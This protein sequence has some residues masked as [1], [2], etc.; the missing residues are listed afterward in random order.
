MLTQ[1]DYM[2]LTKRLGQVGASQLPMHYLLAMRAPYSPTQWLTRLSHEQLKASHQMLGRIIYLLL[3]LHAAFYLNFFV[4][5]GFL[6]KRIKDWDVIFGIISITLFTIVSTTA[7]SFVRRRSYRVFY[8]SHIAIANLIIVPLYLH[9]SHIRIIVYQ[10]VLVEALHVI[11]R[12]LRFRLYQGTIRL[13]P[14][15]NLV[16]IRVPLP[17]SSSALK[18]RPGQHV[19]LS[20]PWGKAKA[21]SFY[22]RWLMINKT[23][24]FT[25]ASIP[26]K[27][28][29]VSTHRK[30]DERQY[31]I[32][33]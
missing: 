14:G 12:A 24:P 3:A 21:P 26:A 2:H 18:W 7:L 11:F 17:I 30:N 5:S 15:T 6:A 1:I 28:K 22:D 33:R 10:V 31:E 23:N 20:R 25:V 4:L 8:I 19:Y 29:E 27:D 16:Q 13:L 9:V 32:S